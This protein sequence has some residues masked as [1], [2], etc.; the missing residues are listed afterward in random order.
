MP[1]GEIEPGQVERLKEI[2]NWL[3]KYGQSIY[4]TRGGPFK[5][6]LWGAST[7]KDNVIYLHVFSWQ[8]FPP[9]LPPISKKIISSEV[10]TGGTIDIK[11]DKNGIAVS[12][13]KQYQ[14]DIDTIIKLTLDGPANQIT[15][16]GCAVRF[17]G[18]T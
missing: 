9:L 10:L 18:G 8:D 4:A 3:S 6:G 14:N 17:S 13:P 1:T 15:P 16:A 5:P 2:G 11:Q 7:Y 12:V